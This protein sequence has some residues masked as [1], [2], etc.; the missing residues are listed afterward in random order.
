MTK[1]LATAGLVLT[2]IGAAFGAHGTYLSRHDA[3]E[4]GVTRFAGQTE[5]QN[6]QLPAVRN[7]LRQSRFAQWGFILIA[8]GT[9]L[10]LVCVWIP[11]N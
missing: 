10:Q 9:G 4:V 2:L 6:L 1:G 7:L 3:I 11:S 8:I 5:A